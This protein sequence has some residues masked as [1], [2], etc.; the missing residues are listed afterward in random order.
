MRPSFFAINI[1][2][3]AEQKERRTKLCKP[4]DKS[5][6]RERLSELSLAEMEEFVRFD[7]ESKP[8]FR[9]ESR[10]EESVK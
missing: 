1:I 8:E 4:A 7:A 10:L 9:I 2:G 3:L 6:L 5:S